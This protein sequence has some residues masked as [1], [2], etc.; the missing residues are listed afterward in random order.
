MQNANI[1][2]RHQG[3]GPPLPVLEDLDKN[4]CDEPIVLKEIID[5][6]KDIDNNKSPGPDGLSKELFMTF[7]DIFASI[8]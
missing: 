2:T 1:C 5:S 3:V 8:Y 6:I 7:I 4:I